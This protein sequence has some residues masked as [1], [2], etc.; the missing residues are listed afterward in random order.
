MKDR[1]EEAEGGQGW[2][3]KERL[4]WKNDSRLFPVEPFL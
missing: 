2:S 3:G 1:A 4:D